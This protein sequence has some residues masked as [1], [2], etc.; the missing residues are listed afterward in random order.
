M[1]EIH[2]SL[3]NLMTQWGNCFIQQAGLVKEQFGSFFKYHRM[4][5][6][7]MKDVS[8]RPNSKL[9]ALQDARAR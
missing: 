8:P 1:Q 3:A 9:S 4:E 6:E 2:R 7:T 5:G